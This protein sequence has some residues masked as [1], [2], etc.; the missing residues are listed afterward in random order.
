MSRFKNPIE[1]ASC[2]SCGRESHNLGPKTVKLFSRTTVRQPSIT[3][4]DFLRVSCRHCES[5]TVTYCIQDRGNRWYLILNINCVVWNLTISV[6]FNNLRSAYNGLQDGLKGERVTN[7]TAQFC[8]ETS[9]ARTEAQRAATI[10]SAGRTPF[11]FPAASRAATF[12]SL[13]LT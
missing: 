1:C 3:K 13:R 8:N 10:A 6:I 9:L 5:D 4:Y 7:R 2:I 12:A 11:I